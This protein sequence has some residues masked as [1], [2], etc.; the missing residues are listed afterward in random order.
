M[1]LS[2]FL[3]D[4]GATSKRIIRGRVLDSRLRGNDG[5]VAVI[6]HDFGKGAGLC[7]NDGMSNQ[8]SRPRRMSGVLRWFG[9]C[10][11]VVAVVVACLVGYWLLRPNGARVNPALN[12]ESWVAV[13]DGMHNS[14]T[15][16]TF[17]RG[18]FYLI[19]ASSPWHFGSVKCKLVLRRSWDARSWE[20][21]AE[22][23]VPG[24]DIRDPKFA[25]IHDKLFVYVLKNVG[26]NP[27]PFGT[28]V[29]FSDDGSTWAPLEDVK[30]EGWLFWRLKTRDGKTWYVPAYWNEHGKSALF[31]S[32]DG[33]AWSEVSRIYEGDR[34]DETDIEFLPDGRMIST[35]RLEF[36]ERF[37]GDKEACTLISCSEPPYTTWTRV[38]SDVTRLD[39]PCLFAYGGAVYAA[40]RHNPDRRW[41][42]DYYGSILGRK[43]TAL[44]KVEENR[45]VYL[46]DLPSAGDTSYAGVVIRGDN[47]YVSYYSNRIDRDYPWIVGM[48]S[49]SDIRIARVSLSALGL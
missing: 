43:R 37:W 16:L 9:I 23:S 14:N 24:Q 2:L 40:G 27:E 48:L 22:F 25:V 41:F 11:A 17:W 15:D 5:G 18:Q 3:Y 35:A 29:T 7:Q 49:A 34:N 4:Q 33:L 31:D 19:H 42:L 32:V 6:G 44:Y 36:S 10:L 46:S 8:V 13:G 20:P 28:A 1:A 30:P 21:V 38:K 26:F 39:G 45:L 47:L 12:V